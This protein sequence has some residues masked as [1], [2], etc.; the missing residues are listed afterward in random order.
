MHGADVEG[1]GRCRLQMGLLFG[2]QVHGPLMDLTVDTYV[3]DGLEPMQGG[4]LQGAGPRVRLQRT[5]PGGAMFNQPIV[6]PFN[7]MGERLQMVLRASDLGAVGDEELVTAIHWRPFGPVIGDVFTDLD[8]RATMDDL[9]FEEVFFANAGRFGDLE[10][11]EN[12]AFVF[13]RR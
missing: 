6:S 13:V 12:H 10:R 5:I 9:G 3:R 1:L 4:R 2:E 8:L 7:P 11:F